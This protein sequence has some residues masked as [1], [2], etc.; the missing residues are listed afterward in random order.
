MLSFLSASPPPQQ[1]F[2]L[3]SWGPLQNL[4]YLAC[5]LPMTPL[6][7]GTKK[8]RKARETEG[9]HRTP[10][11]CRHNQL[12]RNN[13]KSDCM[14]RCSHPLAISYPRKDPRPCWEEFT[15]TSKVSQDLHLLRLL[16]CS[17]SGHIFAPIR[18][19]YSNKRCPSVGVFDCV[20][21]PKCQAG[22]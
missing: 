9:G 5:C 1:L 18:D 6:P 15:L 10:A 13:E 22:R 17:S 8:E 19:F 14:S 21:F 7:A 12:I 16:S 11:S 20:R 2:S 3:A 4:P